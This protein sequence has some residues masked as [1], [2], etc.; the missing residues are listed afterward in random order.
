MPSTATA[1]FRVLDADK[2]QDFTQEAF[3]RTWKYIVGGGEIENVRAFLYR[4]AT[5]VIIDDS[6]KKKSVSLDLMQEKGFDVRLDNSGRLDEIIDAKEG[7]KIIEQ[8]DEKYRE[9]VTMRYLAELSPKEI[10]EILGETENAVSVRIHRGLQKLREIA[11]D[12]HG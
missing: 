6:R 5:N 3:I 9:V 2:A 4:V 7:A 10:A 1:I 12:H 8:L 11:A